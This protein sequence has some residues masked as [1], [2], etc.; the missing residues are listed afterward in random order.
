MQNLQPLPLPPSASS[1]NIQDDPPHL[2]ARECKCAQEFEH[3]KFVEQHRLMSP[4]GVVGA[5]IQQALE[6]RLNDLLGKQG[7]CKVSVTSANEEQRYMHSLSPWKGDEGV[8]CV[9][10]SLQV[11]IGNAHERRLAQMLDLLCES[12]GD[13]AKALGFALAQHLADL[14]PSFTDSSALTTLLL[15]LKRAY[16]YGTAARYNEAPDQVQVDYEMKDLTCA[17]VTVRLRAAPPACPVCSQPV[18][19]LKSITSSTPTASMNPRP[20]PPSVS[21]EAFPAS[22]MPR[23]GTNTPPHTF[24]KLNAASTSPK[25]ASTKSVSASACIA[26]E[27]ESPLPLGWTRHWGKSKRQFYYFH[28]LNNPNP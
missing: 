18:I 5:A 24:S 14:L 27:G 2:G 15:S 22:L 28:A 8:S 11:K 10:A 17:L 6:V 1:S 3:S 4:D 16:I 25:T 20:Q 19:E 23:P 13:E 9:Q 21:Q 26:Q 7:S 12:T